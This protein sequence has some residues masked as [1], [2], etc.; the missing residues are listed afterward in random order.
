[1]N[2]APLLGRT[3]AELKEIAQ[4]VGLPA[5]TGKQIADWIYKKHVTSIDQMTNISVKGREA[6][7]AE[8]CIGITEPSWSAASVDGTKKYLFQTAH[9]QIETVFIP[10][11]DRGT[12]CVSCQVGCKMN[13]QFCMTGKQG[14]SG[15]LTAAEIMNQICGIPEVDRLTNIVF[16]GMGEPFDNT[17]EILR[18]CEIL[19]ADWGFAWSPR[20]IT[21]SSVGLIPGMKEFLDKTEC[22]LAISLHN[23]FPDERIKI[24]P[25]EKAYSITRVIDEI[26]K[27]DWEHQRRISFEYIVFEGLNDM[28][29]HASELVRLLKGFTCRVNLIRWHAIPGMD[30][31]S[32]N[33]E[34]MIWLRDYLTDNGVICT[35][36][37]S[38]GEDIM[39]ACG[40][41]SSNHKH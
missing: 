18:T 16:M 32:P 14:W 4:K 15:S 27:Y 31:H 28:Q 8:Y 40:L 21:V 11:D 13:C 10:E 3:L 19:T 25:A 17:L 9:G 29:R 34:R 36:R 39:A 24:M 33:D 26:K 2:M 1:M 6:L 12:L 38:R 22:H 23:P 5:F 30:M 35:I 41:L 7:K 20:R 37:R